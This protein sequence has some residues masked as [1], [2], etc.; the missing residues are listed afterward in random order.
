MVSIAR[1]QL[2]P[3]VRAGDGKGLKPW[4]GWG[5]QR[6]EAVGADGDDKGMKP[7]VWMS[8]AGDEAVG[9]DGAFIRCLIRIHTLVF[10]PIAIESRPIAQ[11][12]RGVHVV[13]LGVPLMR[14]SCLCGA[15]TA[16]TCRCETMVP[17]LRRRDPVAYD[18]S[19]DH[20]LPGKRDCLR[21]ASRSASISRSFN[22]SSTIMPSAMRSKAFRIFQPCALVS[23]LSCS[24]D[25]IA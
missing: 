11:H 5:R 25:A 15:P 22:A 2:W 17:R 1:D 14:S 6:D 4:C 23:S 18:V 16:L 19:P 7:L 24:S 8:I 3:M 21:S 20:D 9:A 12:R 10:V 13:A